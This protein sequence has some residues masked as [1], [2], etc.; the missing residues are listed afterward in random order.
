MF[1]LIL[2]PPAETDARDAALWY[3]RQRYGLGA[4][5]LLTLE[6]EFTAI[7]RTP[8]LP[9]E[10]RLGFRRRIL[11]RFPYTIIYKIEDQSIIIVAIWHFK[12]KPW[13]W[14]RNK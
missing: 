9:A 8:F 13:K 7:T 3:E 10:Q 5:F 14:K 2:S 4:D 11:K 1:N 6:A 12:R